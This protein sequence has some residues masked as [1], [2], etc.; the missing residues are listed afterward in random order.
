MKTVSEMSNSVTVA[1][2]GD[3]L[4]QEI[5]EHAQLHLLTSSQK[6]QDD[7]G[8]RRGAG[9]ALEAAAAFTAQAAEQDPL[10]RKQHK[11][12]ET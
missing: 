1:V 6:T 5:D 8:T 10:R 3:G 2:M 11:N 7:G 4:Q 9:L 12:P